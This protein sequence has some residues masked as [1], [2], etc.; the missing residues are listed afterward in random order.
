MVV[1]YGRFRSSILSRHACVPHK[2]PPIELIPKMLTVYTYTLSPLKHRRILDQLNTWTFRTSANVGPQATRSRTGPLHT[3]NGIVVNARVLQAAGECPFRTTW[4][5]CGINLCNSSSVSELPSMWSCGSICL[6]TDTFPF[7]F[8]QKTKRCGSNCRQP[9]PKTL[10]DS[11]AARIAVS[12]TS[13][14][15][16]APPHGETQKE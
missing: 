12:P 5:R 3:T 9:D 16:C 7:S 10:A 8:S 11:N 2:T 4:Y 14:L 6:T 15:T 1:L 13:L